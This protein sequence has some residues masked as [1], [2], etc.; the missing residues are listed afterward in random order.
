MKNSPTTFLTRAALVA[1]LAIAISA[2][3]SSS[4][5][6]I[7]GEAAAAASSTA[8]IAVVAEADIEEEVL[9]EKVPEQ[10]VLEEEVSAAPTALPAP[11]ETVLEET[12]TEETAEP[13]EADAADAADLE[14]ELDEVEPVE[15][16]DQAEP[17]ADV[18][19]VSTLVVD[20]VFEPVIAE[21]EAGTSVPL[22]VPAVLNHNEGDAY[23]SLLILG[24]DDYWVS[25]GLVP[26]CDG[27]GACS[28]GTVTGS[29]IDSDSERLS[30]GVPV[31]LPNGLEGQYFEATCGASCGD[32][33]LTWTEGDYMYHVGRKGG[34]AAQLMEWA[35]SAI[36]PE[37]TPPRPPAACDSVNMIDIDAERQ[38]AIEIADAGTGLYWVVSCGPEGVRSG[39]IN[40]SATPRL[41]EPGE[42]PLVALAAFNDSVIVYSGTFPLIDQSGTG[43]P[44]RFNDLRCGTDGSAIELFGD[45][46]TGRVFN[47]FGQEVIHEGAIEVAA[48]DAC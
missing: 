45:A 18:A 11:E 1:G 44:V 30:G 34:G 48:L 13:T 19:A 24:E 25:L 17:V 16:I 21:V 29:K 14:E 35:W 5:G 8:T 42:A 12:N 15:E 26:N 43:L 22:R 3:S 27:G 38:L 46:T 40:G 32:A 7:E 36:A 41:L 4:G 9:G 20:P 28:L 31:P 10:E 37:Q 23:A 39:V 6:A 2:C 33:I 47:R